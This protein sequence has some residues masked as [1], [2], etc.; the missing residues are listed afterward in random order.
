[1]GT[2]SLLPY[3][4][5]GGSTGRV[6]GLTVERSAKLVS[7]KNWNAHLDHLIFPQH[8][9]DKR[10]ITRYKNKR[11][12]NIKFVFNNLTGATMLAYKQDPPEQGI[13]DHTR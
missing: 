7:G 1:M 9:M 6:Y 3:G 2:P 13:P 8:F 5:G 4:T 12:R 11:L 10:V